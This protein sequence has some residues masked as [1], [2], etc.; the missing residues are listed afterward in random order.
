M[1]DN[2]KI[3][4]IY[5]CEYIKKNGEMYPLQKWYNNLIDKK[6]SEIELS[7]VL[8]MI[9]QNEFVNIAVEKAIDYLK[10]N[11]FI[12]EMYEGELLESLF[13]ID[14]SNIIYYL[15]DLKNILYNALIANKNYEWLNE[16]ERNE[17]TEIIKM[18][19]DKIKGIQN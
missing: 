6:I 18:F 7:D 4:E 3:K 10:K 11:P 13:N 16:N 12:G 17:F 15:G 5:M 14:I 2:R 8:R 1:Q 19:L 9:H